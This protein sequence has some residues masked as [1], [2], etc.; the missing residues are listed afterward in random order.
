MR[1][2]STRQQSGSARTNTEI[3]CWWHQDLRYRSSSA[4]GG[5]FTTFYWNI[6]IL[7]ILFVRDSLQPENSIKSSFW[8]VRTCS[9]QE[10]EWW[11]SENQSV[12]SVSQ[13]PTPAVSMSSSGKVLAV[14]RSVWES[15]NY[16]KGA[17]GT[18]EGS[19][20][21]ARLCVNVKPF[22]ETL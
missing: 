14:G 11:P 13:S 8:W 5:I 17:G 7:L 21:R 10:V 6:N 1:S 2:I 9:S 20:R 18:S 22:E 19:V 4:G 15:G 16:C 12:S 3:M